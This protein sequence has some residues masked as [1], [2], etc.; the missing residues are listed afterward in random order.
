MAASRRSEF[1]KQ[2][3]DKNRTVKLMGFGHR[4][5]KNY[6]PRKLMRETC[7]EVLDG[8][9]PAPTTRC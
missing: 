3:K 8:A 5:C 1:I 6:D 2:V 7:H 4:V 9:G